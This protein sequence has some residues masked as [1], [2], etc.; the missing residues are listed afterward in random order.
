MERKLIKFYADWCG[1][2]KIYAPVV[3]RVASA[4]DLELVTVNVDEEQEL[5]KQYGVQGIPTLILEENGEEIARHTGA[6]STARTA[7][8]LG[9]S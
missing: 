8:A 9:L 5:M 7:A 6:T 2:C 1:P 4:H 3:E